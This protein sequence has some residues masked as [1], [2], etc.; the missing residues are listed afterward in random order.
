MP[1]YLYKNPKTEEIIE[2]IQSMN[3]KHVYIDK[4]GIEW[5][6]VWTVPQ[7]NIDTKIDPF[8]E[9]DFVKY[10]GARKG[11]LGDLQDLSKAMSEERASKNGGIDEVKEHYYDVQEKTTGVK[12]FERKK[13]EAN[14]KLS[15]LGVEIK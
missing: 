3:E 2:I 8:S 1:T 9:K 4:N 13:R 10:T 12:S 7:S 15:K 14:K 5:E 11:T 6:R